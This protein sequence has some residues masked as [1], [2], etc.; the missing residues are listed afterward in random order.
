MYFLF[1]WLRRFIWKQLR[2]CKQRFIFYFVFIIIHIINI[3]IMSGLTQKNST[4]EYNY[5][6]FLGEFTTQIWKIIFQCHSIKSCTSK[7][8]KV[9][10]K[11]KT[12]Q[13][14][15]I[16]IKS[17]HHFP[18]NS[19]NKAREEFWGGFRGGVFWCGLETAH[20]RDITGMAGMCRC[21]VGRGIL[22][23]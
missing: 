11:K 7:F 8:Y 2:Y 3:Q 4:G 15:I 14:F 18:V 6:K 23:R 5:V 1:C 22:H 20:G 17:T 19:N 9:H 21:V 10:W 16:V 12:T 13:W